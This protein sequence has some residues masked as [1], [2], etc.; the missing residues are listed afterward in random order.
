MF[1]VRE[2]KNRFKITAAMWNA[3]AGFINNFCGSECV[4]V[5]RPDHPSSSAP[6]RVELDYSATIKKIDADVNKVI[7]PE[8]PRQQGESAPGAT[9]L[10]GGYSGGSSFS[11]LADGG[12]TMAGSLDKGVKIKVISRAV[13]NG[14]TTALF[15]RE[16]TV[17]GDGRI[18]KVSEELQEPALVY[19]SV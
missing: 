2:V 6:V 18:Y 8:T 14:Q 12:Q 7:D 19:T 3:V 16:I 10:D 11:P 13:D 15:F 4:K 17:S 9:E 5:E 1:H